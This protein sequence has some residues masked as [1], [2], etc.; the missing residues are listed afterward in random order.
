MNA[1]E[2]LG[3]RLLKSKKNTY[4]N[5]NTT[6]CEHIRFVKVDGEWCA[7]PIFMGWGQ[8][9][10]PLAI[11]IATAKAIEELLEELNEIR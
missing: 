8:R 11:N 1:L 2:K 10:F 3:W 7:A 9:E 6:N 4:T 5:E